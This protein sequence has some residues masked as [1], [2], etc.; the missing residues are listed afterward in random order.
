MIAHAPG[1][2]S[3]ISITRSVGD[4]SRTFSSPV[5]RFTATR[6]QAGII[7]LAI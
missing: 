2:L 6:Y 5:W 1:K 4:F 7:P 3:T